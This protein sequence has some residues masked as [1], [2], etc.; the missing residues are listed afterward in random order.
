MNAV[1]NICAMAHDLDPEQLEVAEQFMSI[2][3]AKSRKVRERAAANANNLAA[4]MPPV[5]VVRGE[6]CA[7]NLASVDPACYFLAAS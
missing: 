6:V 5:P 2:L 4:E 1:K 3:R 7:A